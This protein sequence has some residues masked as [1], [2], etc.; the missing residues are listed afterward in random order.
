MMGFTPKNHPFWLQN[1]V[2]TPNSR[3]PGVIPR[4]LGGIL[5]VGML[6]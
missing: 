1:S 5:T 3:I 2:F 6:E 4:L